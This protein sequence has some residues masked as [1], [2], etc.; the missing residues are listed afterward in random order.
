MEKVDLNRYEA[1]GILGTG[2]DY[3]VRAAVD[4]ETGQQVVLKRPKPQMVSRSL[5]G[6][7]EER[8]E[9]IL[10]VYQEVGHALPHISP[11]LAYTERANH[12]A[13]FGESLGQE[14]RVIIE[15]RAKGIPLVGDPMAR[16]TGVPI[17]L[18]Q[19]LFALFP[20]AHPDTATPFA[21]HQQLLDLEE[22]FY[23]AGHVLLDL[24]PQ[25]VFFQPGS[26]TATV[27]DCGAL[28]AKTTGSPGLEGPEH[29]A[30]VSSAFRPTRRP[31]PQDIHD[32]YLEMLKFYVTPLEPA[33]EARGYRDAY[34]L[35]PVVRFEQELDE[36]ARNFSKVA[37][38]AV[39]EAALSTI[40]KVRRRGY[41][42]FA[43]FREDLTAYLE[44]VRVRNRNLPNLAQ[45]RQAWV[46]ASNLLREDYWRR[47][48]FDPDIE[49]EQ[50]RAL[51]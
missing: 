43:D 27:I 22:G 40:A 1:L 25:N 19:N 9:R 21:V 30:S 11:I 29:R 5:H 8:T 51:A 18:G 38:L 17:G 31:S 20:L 16:I 24:R 26:S 34:G 42:T 4:R 33:T 46:E 32:F 6:R 48:L 50:F 49:L 37:D 3:E 15:A 2:A 41:D 47:Y 13:Y 36:M 45:A 14:Y 7:T 10:Q 44:F 28:V 39:R 12:D 35:R 23:R